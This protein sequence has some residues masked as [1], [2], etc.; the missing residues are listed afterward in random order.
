MKNCL[1]KC[2]PETGVLLEGRSAD[3]RLSPVAVLVGSLLLLKSQDKSLPLFETELT[4][5]KF[6]AL[7]HQS[8]FSHR[9]ILC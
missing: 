6:D 2:D 1:P 5:W 9:Y 3:G 4:A 8:A 7:G